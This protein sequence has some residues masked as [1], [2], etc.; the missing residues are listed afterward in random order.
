VEDVLGIRKL[1]LIEEL[2]EKREDPVQVLITWKKTPRELFASA[3]C[4]KGS[5]NVQEFQRMRS[6]VEGKPKKGLHQGY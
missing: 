3:G 6:G 2:A 5:G 1:G 4:S